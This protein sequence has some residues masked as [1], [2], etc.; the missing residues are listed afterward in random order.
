M[1]TP[2]VLPDF[3]ASFVPMSVKFA[4]TGDVYGVVLPPFVHPVPKQPSFSMPCGSAAR[5][6]APVRCGI[7]WFAV[8]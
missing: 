2:P 6:P 5:E 7:A 3:A 1:P 4:T 8:R